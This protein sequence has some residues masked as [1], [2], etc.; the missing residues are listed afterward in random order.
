MAVAHR[1]LGVGPHICDV[2]L[3]P[4]GDP[5]A[6]AHNGTMADWISDPTLSAEDKLKHFESL[7]PS[8]TRGPI[9]VDMPCATTG[10]RADLTFSGAVVLSAGIDASFVPRMPY[11][12]AP[13]ALSANSVGNV[14]AST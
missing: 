14:P 3:I 1:V 13:G 9:P 7:G 8:L 6:C 5:W 4:S 12:S 10:S 2:S 11:T